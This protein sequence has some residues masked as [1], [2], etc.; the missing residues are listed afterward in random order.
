MVGV[1]STTVIS[2]VSVSSAPM[3]WYST[4]R[5]PPTW[6]QHTQAFGQPLQMISLTQLSEPSICLNDT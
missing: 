3:L 4:S 2:M 1:M 6:L 5:A